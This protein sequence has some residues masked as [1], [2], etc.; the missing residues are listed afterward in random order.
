MEVQ[1]WEGPNWQ[2]DERR[3]GLLRRLQAIEGQVK[4]IQR[5]V[6]EGRPCF[7]VLTQIAAVQQ[8]LRS[9]AK[10]TL[11]HYLETC[12]KT[13]LCAEE[14]PAEAYDELMEMVFKFAR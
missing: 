7:E 9:A 4:G 2:E 12:A 6:R 13:V 1:C 8:A 11:R 5:M 10:V 14:V 3:R